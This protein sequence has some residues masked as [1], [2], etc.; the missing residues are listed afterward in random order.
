MRVLIALLDLIG[1]AW[2]APNTLIGLCLGGIGQ[3]FG[4]TVGIAHNAI[5]FRDNALMNALHPG[6]AITI[7]NVIIYGRQAYLLA[8]HERVHTLQGQFTGPLYLPLN[9]IGMLLSVLSWPVVG[10]R[11]PGCSPFHGHLNFME[12]RPRCATLYGCAAPNPKQG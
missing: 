9:A 2:N 10:L 11:R 1:K 8:A 5:E 12:G 4:G 7:G 6:G 3:A